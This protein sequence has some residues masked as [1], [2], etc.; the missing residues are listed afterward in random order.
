MSKELE[1]KVGDKVLGLENG[2]WVEDVVVEVDEEDADMKYRTKE[3]HDD[4]HNGRGSWQFMDDIRVIKADWPIFLEIP[5]RAH[6]SALLPLE[7][8]GESK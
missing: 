4:S 1:L 8:C 6:V 3:V 5:D 2:E 7:F